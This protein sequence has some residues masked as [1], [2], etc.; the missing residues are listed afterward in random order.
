VNKGKRYVEALKGFDRDRLYPPVEALELVK[1]L[2][3]ARF[4]ETIEL[5]RDSA[6]IHVVPTRSS[7]ARSRCPRALD[8]WYALLSLPPAKTLPRRVPLVP[9]SSELTT[10]SSESRGGLSRFRRR[11]SHAGPDGSGGRLGRV[12]GPVA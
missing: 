3:K 1:S 8:G 11:H 2:A 12:L 5:A 4:D 10:S 9:T 6:S 7:V